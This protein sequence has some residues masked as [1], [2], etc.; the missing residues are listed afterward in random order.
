MQDQ[1]WDDLRIVLNVARVSSF[2]AAARKLGINESTVARRIHAAETRLNATLFERSNGK[3]ILTESGLE[4]IKRAENIEREIQ[5]A[6]SKVSGTDMRVSGTVRVTSVPIILHNFIVPALPHLLNMNPSLTVEL[7]SNQRDLSLTKRETDIAL[8]LARPQTEGRAIS[9]RVGTIEYAVYGAS[10]DQK[11]PLPW[12]NYE[13]QMSDLPHSQW[14]TSR[15][16]KDKSDE[17]RVL[18]NDAEMILHCIKAGLGKSLLP[19]CVGDK[20]EGLIQLEEFPETMSRELWLIVHPDM[21]NLARVRT[22]MD[23]LIQTLN[24]AH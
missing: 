7:I 22:V 5:A 14:M 19:L 2:A 6:Q 10:N 8:R 1:N 11:E 23:W 24:K 15:Y 4:I 18:V 12:I 9:R 17:P 16:A 20:I 3:L 21:R 13:D